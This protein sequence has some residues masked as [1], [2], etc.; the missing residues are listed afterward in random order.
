VRHLDQQPQDVVGV[1][2][3]PGLER[4]EVKLADLGGQLGELRVPR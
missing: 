3:E 4:L 2:V 1:G